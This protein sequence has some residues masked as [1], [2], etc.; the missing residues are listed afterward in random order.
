MIYGQCLP[1]ATLAHLLSVVS[2]RQGL[3][4]RAELSSLQCSA[5]RG[6]GTGECSM[7]PACI[8]ACGQRLPVASIC[9]RP[10]GTC[11]MGYAALP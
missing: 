3:G 2:A 11:D 6:L 1:P 7:L 4:D 9:L 8:P 5:G 10:A